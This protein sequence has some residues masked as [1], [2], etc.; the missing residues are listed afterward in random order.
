M[1]YTFPVSSRLS[2][3]SLPR[4]G[5][6]LAAAFALALVTF[7]AFSATLGNA[8][9]D[10][11]D[12]YVI[13]FNPAIKHINLETLHR[14]FFSYDPEL[15]V[16][17]TLFTF[18]IDYFLAGLNPAIYHLQSL[19]WHIG[20]VVLLAWIAWLLTRDRIAALLTAVLFAV[21]PLNVEAVAWASGRKDVLST[22]WLLLSVL[23]YLY[24]RGSGSKKTYAASLVAFALS[25]LAKVMT[26]T[27][28]FVLLLIDWAQGRADRKKLLL[29]K[30][31]YLAL[32][33]LFGVI[34]M[35]G[36]QEVNAASTL[37]E[38]ILMAAKS[39]TFYLQ[40]L[41]LPVDLAVVYPYR[42]AITLASPDFFVPM[43]V[44][45]ALVVALLWLAR[46]HRVIAACGAFFL[47]TLAPTFL[48]FFKAG[49]AYFA[50]DRYAYVPSIG[51]FLLVGIG[52]GLLARRRDRET[53]VLAVSTVACAVLCVLCYRQVTIWK[54][55]ET[56]FLHNLAL[57]PDTVQLRTN[58]AQVYRDSGR[59]DDAREQLQLALQTEQSAHVY[60]SIA[61]LDAAE[62]KIADAI[63]LYRKAAALDPTDTDPH[64]GMGIIEAERK[65]YAA[66]EKHYTDALAIKPRFTPAY[67]NLGAVY[68][69]QERWAEAEAVYAKALE[70]DSS[71]IDARYNYAHLLERKGDL[72]GAIREYRRILQLDPDYADAMALLAQVQVKAGDLDG[73]IATARDALEEEPDA[74]EI[75]KAALDTIRAVADK[76]PTN[77]A[78]KALLEEMQERGMLKKK[79][80]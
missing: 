78:A 19:L 66:A 48:N 58:L 25:L 57:Y 31:P 7:V 24:Y 2:L 10:W 55:T 26:L 71:Y 59:N 6:A 76:D 32:S 28:P 1:M 5:L 51:A 9:V 56:L 61:A 73:A 22:F 50:S 41:V 43:I 38:K 46:R 11:D 67:N 54:N 21:H 16:P 39:T 52:A 30:L 36:K 69:E 14:I 15:Y 44:V 29:E 64:F 37:W 12:T 70:I 79:T 34:G 77:A 18:Q 80:P 62:G 45:S 75:Q 40:K 8:F 68:L 53:G 27:L 72:A 74:P 60:A 33:V 42:G 65:N 63:A 3:P 4:R 47:L 13:Y 17:F 23:L 20:S 49:Q 35:F